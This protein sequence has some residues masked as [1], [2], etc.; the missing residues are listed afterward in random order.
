[1]SSVISFLR[2]HTE[3]PSQCNEARKLKRKNKNE[4]KEI[5]RLSADDMVVYIGKS[6]EPTKKANTNI[7]HVPTYPQG[8]AGM[9]S[10]LNNI[11]LS[12]QL[13]A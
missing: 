13:S 7:S 5:R 9:G 6:E 8:T 3:S 1:M 10:F 11:L 4:K 12:P 2:H